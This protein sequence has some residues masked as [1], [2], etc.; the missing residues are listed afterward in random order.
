MRRPISAGRREGLREDVGKPQLPRLPPDP[1]S[2]LQFILLQ[3]STESLGLG[4]GWYAGWDWTHCFCSWDSVTLPQL[5]RGRLSNTPL[6][7]SAVTW[8]PLGALISVLATLSALPQMPGVGIYIYGYY[9]IRTSR[10]LLPWA[11]SSSWV[12]VMCPCSLCFFG[13]EV[14]ED[15]VCEVA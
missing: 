11:S 10:S 5:L 13:W 14:R 6:S 1:S 9:L 7:P 12:S 4:L 8:R 15:S 2:R 3:E